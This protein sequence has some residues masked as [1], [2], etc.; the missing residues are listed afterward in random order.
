MLFYAN[1]QKEIYTKEFK[2]VYKPTNHVYHYVQYEYSSRECLYK[3]KGMY[4]TLHI[5][6]YSCKVPNSSSNNPT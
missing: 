5:L 4:Y 3:D 2:V 6:R 1:G